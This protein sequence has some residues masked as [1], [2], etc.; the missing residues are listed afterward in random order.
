[1]SKKRR[2]D[3][4]AER[5]QLALE[6]GPEAMS[7]RQLARTVAKRHPDVPG[8]SYAGV[9]QYVEGNVRTPRI[10]LL[11]AMAEVLGVRYEWLAFNDGPMTEAAA[12]AS[13]RPALS[14][15]P[16]QLQR[17]RAAVFKAFRR[18]ADALLPIGLESGERVILPAVEA[19]VNKMANESGDEPRK[20]DYI[21]AGRLLGHAAMAPLRILGLAPEYW[22]AGAKLQY[23]AH[24][25][26]TLATL[27][28]LEHGLGAMLRTLSTAPASLG[29]ELQA[30]GGAAAAALT[31]A[32]ED[33]D[34]TP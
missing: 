4:Y 30:G 12:E 1:M 10:K 32:L 24:T 20:D 5:L 23:L 19:V 21:T 34:A 17:T 28:E 27:V 31:R 9:R 7:V 14:R 3:G 13:R 8:R 25:L 22:T 2:T 16:E 18:E 26:P 11:Q 33:D 29:E 6:V 15:S